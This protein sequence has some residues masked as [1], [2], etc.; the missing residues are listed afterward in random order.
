[1]TTPP[2]EAF[3]LKNPSKQTLNKAHAG[4]VTTIKAS[5]NMRS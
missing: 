5:M 4:Y 1:V 3:K 2:R